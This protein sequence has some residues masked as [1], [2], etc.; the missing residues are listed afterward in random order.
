MVNPRNLTTT[1]FTASLVCAFSAVSFVRQMITPA[2]AQASGDPCAQAGCWTEAW[3][4]CVWEYCYNTLCQ[5]NGSSWDCP[6]CEETLECANNMLAT[7]CP[8]GGAYS[9]C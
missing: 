1:V 3:D 4:E 2:S 9:G 6:S 7:Y 8:G 5:W